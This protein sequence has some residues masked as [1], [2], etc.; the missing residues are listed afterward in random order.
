MT[1]ILTTSSFCYSN[2]SFFSFNF[3]IQAFVLL[4][5]V[6][7]FMC[8]Y[9]R[10]ALTCLRLFQ[11]ASPFDLKTQYLEQAKVSVLAIAHVRAR[12]LCV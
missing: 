2:Q 10:A 11:E 7:R 1:Y 4:L 12:A 3:I 5:E 6:Q 8:D 9:S